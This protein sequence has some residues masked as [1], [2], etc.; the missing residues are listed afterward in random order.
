MTSMWGLSSPVKTTP[1]GVC[2]TTMLRTLRLAKDRLLTAAGGSDERV[3][4]ARSTRRAQPGI[5][6]KSD[7]GWGGTRHRAEPLSVAMHL[8]DMRV[9]HALRPQCE[10]EEA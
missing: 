10:M 6:H 8:V 7:L 5:R 3:S 1:T 4:G 2:R 9:Q